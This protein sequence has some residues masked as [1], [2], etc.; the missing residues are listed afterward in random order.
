M[1]PDEYLKQAYSV[2]SGRLGGSFE[3]WMLSNERT[4]EEME[5]YANAMKNGDRFPLPWINY[6]S[7][8]QDGRNR[9]LAA[10]HLGMKE[11]PVGIIP[12]KSTSEQIEEILKELETATGYKKFRLEAQLQRLRDE[13]DN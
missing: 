3:G 13:Q 6:D 5:A 1:T 10:K 4:R 7:G 8:S 2:T 9:A 11:I 12:Q